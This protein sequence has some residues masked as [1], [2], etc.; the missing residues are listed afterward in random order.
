M[1]VVVIAAAIFGF[2]PVAQAGADQVGAT[3]AQVNSLAGRI[4]AGAANLH[5]LGMA[6]DAARAQASLADQQIIDAQRQI[7]TA[8]H[9]IAA[10][11]SILSRDA[12]QQYM[13]GGNL[14]GLTVLV[15]GKSSQAYVRAAYLNVASGS[16]T[17]AVDKLKL[18]ENQASSG[19]AALKRAQQRSHDALA[20]AAKTRSDA[21]AQVSQEESV[22][23]GLKGSLAV[24]VIQAQ[25]AASHSSAGGPGGQPLPGGLAAVTTPGAQSGGGPSS[26]DFARIRQCE[27]G[28]NYAAD[29][30]NGYYG[31][32][33]ISADTWHGLGYSGLPDDASP[34]TQDQ[35]ARRLQA[36]SGWGQ[37]PTCSAAMGL[38]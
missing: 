30:G 18:Y 6:Y 1:S 10:S 13:A 16:L 32:Y 36:R 19:L 11:R 29:T 26:E 33:Q 21:Q 12:V 4:T 15:R 35:A 24:L 37:W 25:A 23:A 2:L 31:A 17:D 9:Q 5:R 20:A 22:L 3:Q 8:N 34:P 14:S 38:S 7:A 27:S 28:D